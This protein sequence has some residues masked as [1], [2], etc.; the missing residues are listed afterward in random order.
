MCSITLSEKVKSNRLSE[1]KSSALH[2]AILG[3]AV[4]NS[5]TMSPSGL[6]SPKPSPVGSMAVIS[7]PS[8]AS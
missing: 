5:N 2:G 7:N 4:A 6:N 8:A 3:F 1:M